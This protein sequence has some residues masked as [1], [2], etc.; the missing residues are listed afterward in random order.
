MPER[1]QNKSF[2]F[3]VILC[4]FSIMNIFKFLLINTFVHSCNTCKKYFTLTVS[5]K[6]TATAS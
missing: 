1:F 3:Y 5:N 4:H 6:Y 2:I